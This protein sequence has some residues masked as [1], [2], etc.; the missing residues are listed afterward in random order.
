MK[1][2]MQTFYLNDTEIQYLLII[3]IENKEAQVN[4]I[5]KIFNRS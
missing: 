3:D 5:E 2:N 1:R 4:G